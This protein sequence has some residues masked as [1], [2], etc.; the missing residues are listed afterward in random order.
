MRT[1]A[2]CLVKKCITRPSSCSSVVS[3]FACSSSA[4]RCTG[5]QLRRDPE[6]RW[7]S[8]SGRCF[9]SIRRRWC[10]IFFNSVSSSTACHRGIASGQSVSNAIGMS[11]SNV[12]QDL[13][14]QVLKVKWSLSMK[15]APALI[16]SLMKFSATTGGSGIHVPA[17]P[18]AA[19]RVIQLE[20]APAETPSLCLLHEGSSSSSSAAAAG[21]GGS[22]G[23]GSAAI[24][25]SSSSSGDGERGTS[26]LRRTPVKLSKGTLLVPILVTRPQKCLCELCLH[27]A[28]GDDCFFIEHPIRWWCL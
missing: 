22:G 19:Q 15:M 28:A 6:H 12:S 3:R 10:V 18:G 5:D 20:R 7:L 27:K 1:Y 16:P 11:V 2:Y 9:F 25:G 13:N 21:S 17:A 26:F 14:E 23:G 8:G 24:S 4:L